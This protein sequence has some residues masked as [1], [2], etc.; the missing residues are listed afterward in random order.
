VDPELP[1][2]P[3]LGVHVRGAEYPVGDR[4]A[5]AAGVVWPRGVG[6]DPEAAGDRPGG[7]AEATGASGRQ[8]DAQ[9]MRDWGM[10]DPRRVHLIMRWMLAGNQPRVLCCCP[11][12][13]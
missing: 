11:L 4:V 3:D 2:S 12:P 6:E 1:D 7:C 9:T 10:R 13:P 5:E 8:L